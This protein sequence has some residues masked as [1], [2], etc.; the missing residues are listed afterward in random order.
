MKIS[1]FAPRKEKPQKEGEREKR[2][3]ASLPSH[4]KRLQVK[5]EKR[6]KK[7][8]SSKTGF[9]KKKRERG[10]KK[11]R[12]KEKEFS[13]VV[14]LVSTSCLCIVSQLTN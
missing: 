6:G 14:L 13:R 1:F 4:S 10:R 3:F 9:S 12:E 2:S 5:R 8:V 7:N 11:R